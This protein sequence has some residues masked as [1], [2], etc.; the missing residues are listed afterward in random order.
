MDETALVR[1]AARGDREAF[2]LLYDRHA[3]FVYNVAI[4]M[5]YDHGE[6][7]EL[8]QEAFVTAWRKLPGF[9]GGSAF[10]TWLYRIV[11][12]RGIT[13]LRSRRPTQ[14]MSDEAMH[15]RSDDYRFTDDDPLRAAEARQAE[16][17]L[18]A[19]LDRLDPDRRA[20]VILRELEGLAYDEIA[21]IMEVPVGTVR[22]RLAR[23]RDDLA[24]MAREEEA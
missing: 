23:A 10:R 3:R 6:A 17:R 11:V 21:H 1:Q 18:K 13:H 8:T 19:F 15:S 9:R 14:E 22:S 20:T 4:R 2:G 24:A 7:D 12:N 5:V 16:E